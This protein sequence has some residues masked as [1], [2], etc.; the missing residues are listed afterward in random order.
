MLSFSVA[1]LPDEVR[2]AFR[3]NYRDTPS[4]GQNSPAQGPARRVR[5]LTSRR[6]LFSISAILGFS[7]EY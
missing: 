7:E 1:D 3:V 6:E 2:R 5:L 4:A